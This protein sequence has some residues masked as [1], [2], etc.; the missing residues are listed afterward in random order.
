MTKYNEIG[1][2]IEGMCTNSAAF[3]PPTPSPFVDLDLVDNGSLYFTIFMNQ[4]IF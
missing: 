4:D 3:D 1:G 2:K